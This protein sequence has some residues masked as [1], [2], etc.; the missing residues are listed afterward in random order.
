MIG[1]NVFDFVHPDDHAMVIEAFTR[2][3]RHQERG[4]I[5][6]FRVRHR[7]GSWRTLEALGSSVRDDSGA[8]TGLSPLT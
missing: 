1:K 4:E 2:R 7:D 8:T 5:L 3:L 6:E